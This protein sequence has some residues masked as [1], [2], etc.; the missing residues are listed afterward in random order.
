MSRKNVITLS[1]G[2]DSKQKLRAIAH[3]DS[4]SMS[5]MVRRLVDIE[6]DRRK[7]IIYNKRG[8]K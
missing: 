3:T 5:N 8:K 7:E 1:I 2:D 4:R 6:F